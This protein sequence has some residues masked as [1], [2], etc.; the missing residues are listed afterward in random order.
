[1]LRVLHEE[2]MMPEVG[3]RQEEINPREARQ[4]RLGRPV[5]AVLVASVSLVILLLAGLAIGVV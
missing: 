4:G 3:P 2:D 5:L 1:M